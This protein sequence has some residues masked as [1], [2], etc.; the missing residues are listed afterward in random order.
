M[1]YQII[2][3][4]VSGALNYPIKAFDSAEHSK[5]ACRD[6]AVKFMK[7]F[8]I[9]DANMP[10]GF[11]MREHEA[12]L[13]N[14]AR[15]SGDTM[16]YFEAAS[17]VLKYNRGGNREYALSTMLDAARKADRRE[18]V[19]AVVRE[20]ID[21]YPLEAVSTYKRIL[22][23]ETSPS[24]YDVLRSMLKSAGAKLFETGQQ[25]RALEVANILSDHILVEKIAT[26]ATADDVTRYFAGKKSGNVRATKKAVRN[27]VRTN[28]Y[29]ALQ[30]GT[31]GNFRD[32]IVNAAR[33]AISRGY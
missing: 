15:A 32:D 21:S 3:D 7:H 9:L 23:S 4:Q 30:L 5:H 2:P 8:G 29:Y 18:I 24:D 22:Q 14:A 6:L 17:L 33:R 10:P 16:L 25:D 31:A 1:D 20:L 27:L 11:P 12:A 13:V 19:D 26:D 28:A